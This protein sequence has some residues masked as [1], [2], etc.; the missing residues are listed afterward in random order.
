MSPGYLSLLLAL[1][2]LP[3]T[4]VGASRFGKKI[5][6]EL[7]EADLMEDEDPDDNAAFVM[8]KGDDGKLHPTGESRLPKP[9]M[10]FVELKEE[11]NTKKKVE[12]VAEKW[13]SLLWTNGLKVR[14]Y[15]ID[16]NRLLFVVDT[17]LYD[18]DQFKKFALD[19]EETKVLL[20]HDSCNLNPTRMFHPKAFH[21]PHVWIVN[22]LFPGL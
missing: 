3:P 10:M 2:L 21:R 9:E 8:E 16:D 1:A 20:S 15:P 14:P 17:G 12:E 22:F 7:L 11:Y 4:A 6:L 19:Q 13:T 5:D 18:T